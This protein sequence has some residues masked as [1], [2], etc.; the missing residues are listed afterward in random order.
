M[1]IKLIAK[2]LLGKTQQPVEKRRSD[3]GVRWR[4]APSVGSMSLP[5]L[6]RRRRLH[7]YDGTLLYSSDAGHVGDVASFF[8][9]LGEGEAIGTRTR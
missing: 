4:S 8:D 1:E 3:R 7:S 5:C 2:L 9:P 6:C